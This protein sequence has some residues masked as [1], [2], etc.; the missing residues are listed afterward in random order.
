MFCLH[1]LQI[2]CFPKCDV[3]ILLD[4]VY[5]IVIF[6]PIRRLV[7]NEFFNQPVHVIN[8]SNLV[9]RQL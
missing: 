8:Q 4:I 9:I 3:E 6:L 2:L 1:P 7:K 5:Y